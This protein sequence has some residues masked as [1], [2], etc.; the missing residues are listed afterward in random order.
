MLFYCGILCSSC[1]SLTI[2]AKLPY[3]FVLAAGAVP[4]PFDCYLAN[5]GVKTL[6]V[7]MKRHQ[8]NALAVAKFLENS[9]RVK[10]VYYP[11]TC[12]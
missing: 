1:K 9:P 10:K 5:R 6:H 7:R 4:S 12:F 2:C 11:G 3:S 8:E